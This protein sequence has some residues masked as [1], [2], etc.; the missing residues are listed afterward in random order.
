MTF[1]NEYDKYNKSDENKDFNEEALDE[2][3]DN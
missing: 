3:T 1:P 2:E